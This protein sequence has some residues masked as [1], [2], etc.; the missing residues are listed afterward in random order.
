M[1]W[2]SQAK[3]IC[4]SWL[5]YN[6]PISTIWFPIQV[7]H[8]YHLFF[9]Q[10]FK[11]IRQMI[12]E[13]LPIKRITASYERPLWQALWKTFPNVPV[14]GC[15]Y[16]WTLDVWAK[17]V[18]LGLKPLY[19]KHGPTYNYLCKVLALPFLPQP[20]IPTMFTALQAQA[21]GK[22]LEELMAYIDL[23]WITN[24]MFTIA[25][26]STYKRVF[27]TREQ[28]EASLPR[29]RPNQQ[30]PFYMLIRDLHVLSCQLMPMSTL[31]PVNHK[32]MYAFQQEQTSLQGLMIAE[33]DCYLA[34]RCTATMLLNH[35]SDHSAAMLL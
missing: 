22:Q 33:W 26:W 4:M 15:V 16:Q 25:A 30:L 31:T 23:S 11:V 21:G 24:T 19:E 3:I 28:I 17:M 35:C 32:K 27:R 20:H 18:E 29:A 2:C 12:T 5:L 34:G 7:R 1:A 13:N 9:S 8:L 14:Y 6:G 10:V